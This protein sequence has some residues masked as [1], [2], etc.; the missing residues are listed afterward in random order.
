[1]FIGGLRECHGWGMTEDII[2]PCTDKALQLTM[3]FHVCFLTQRLG[4]RNCLSF[5]FSVCLKCEIIDLCSSMPQEGD[6]RIPALFAELKSL[7]IGHA[8]KPY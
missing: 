7:A 1:M 5:H 3:S 8:E 2:R 6:R 4:I